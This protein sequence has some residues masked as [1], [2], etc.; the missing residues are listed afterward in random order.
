MLLDADTVERFLG[1]GSCDFYPEVRRE[2]GLEEMERPAWVE[3]WARREAWV[4]ERRVGAKSWDLAVGR[5]LRE[6]ADRRGTWRLGGG[7]G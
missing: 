1:N 7:E 2:L 6:L 4:R 5:V 3:W